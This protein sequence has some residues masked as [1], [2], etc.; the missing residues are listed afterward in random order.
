M[1]TTVTLDKDVEALVR[2]VMRERGL[3]F[4]QAVN[5]AI[6]QGLTT[7]SER[8]AFRTPTFR[9]GAPR[10]SLTHALRLA[11]ELEDEELARRVSSRK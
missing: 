3:T 11:A 8:P 5:M 10:G 4:K 9:M 2:R 7:D 1:R 6:R